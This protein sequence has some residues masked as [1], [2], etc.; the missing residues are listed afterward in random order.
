MS[1]RNYLKLNL[2]FY[3]PALMEY[4]TDIDIDWDSIDKRLKNEYDKRI[5]ELEKENKESIKVQATIYDIIIEA[6]K[7]NK[8]AIRYLH[9]MNSLF[10][11][12]TLNTDATERKILKKNIENFLNQMNMDYVNYLGEIAVINNLLAQK[13]YKLEGIEEPISN[14]KN[15]DFKLRKTS[16]NTIVLLEIESIHLD[17]DRV[18][19][20][21]EKIRTFITGR[22]MRKINKKKRNLTHNL[23]LYFV[24]VMWGGWRSLKIYSDYFKKNKTN[25]ENVHEP[26]AY[27]LFS[28]DDTGFF[29]NRFGKV[30]NLFKPF[31]L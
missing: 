2:S 30:S 3:L 7:D 6:K 16:D 28:N 10:S 15:I 13:T 11:E 25:I 14:G 5:T 29:V 9:F 1:N 20:D 4:T 19:D 24:F 26:V 31:D 18:E 23:N 8:Q 21:E 22:F 12:L 17:D 27:L